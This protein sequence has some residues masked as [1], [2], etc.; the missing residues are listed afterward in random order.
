MDP[1]ADQLVDRGPSIGQR[2]IS[3]ERVENVLTN[4]PSRIAAAGKRQREVCE[5][6]MTRRR[7]TRRLPI[8]TD[9]GLRVASLVQQSSKMK[10][11]LRLKVVDGNRRAEMSDAVARI[12]RVGN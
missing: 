3:T 8:G 1:R 11:E 6:A 10:V 4:G 12:G 9:G 7:Q 5:C 2:D